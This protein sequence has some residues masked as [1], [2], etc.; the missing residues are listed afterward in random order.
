M[1]FALLISL[2]TVFGKFIGGF[3]IDKFNYK[4]IAPGT[5]LVAGI[6][7]LFPNNVVVSVIGLVAFNVTMPIT[8]FLLVSLFPKFKCTMFGVLTV[9]LFL[10]YLFYTMFPIQNIIFS[11]I[12]LLSNTLLFGLY[13]YLDNKMK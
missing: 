3:L 5:L 11:V 1:Q 4:Y 7:F 2:G 6:C 9:M 12:I 10:G 13:A 8:L